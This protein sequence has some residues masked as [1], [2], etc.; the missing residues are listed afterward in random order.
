VARAIWLG[1]E[2]GFEERSR[3]PSV[4]AGTRSDG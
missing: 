4:L 3:K 1:N 2:W